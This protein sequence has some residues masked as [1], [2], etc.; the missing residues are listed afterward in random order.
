MSPRLLPMN[1]MR[2]TRAAMEGRVRSSPARTQPV[3]R[4]C[5]TPS[6]ADIPIPIFH[7]YMAHHNNDLA[8][9]A[10]E[11]NARYPWP[12]RKPML[13]GRCASFC[14]AV[15]GPCCANAT[16]VWQAARTASSEEPLRAPDA[17]MS[18]TPPF[19]GTAGAPCAAVGADLLL[20][21]QAER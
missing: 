6:H 21:H 12:Q 17:P 11:I 5:K 13:F 20:S 4:F 3:M 2:S 8:S 14:T 15:F 16:R 1:R 10:D 18:T 19:R 7:F 9:R